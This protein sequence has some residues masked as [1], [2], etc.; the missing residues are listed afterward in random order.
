MTRKLPTYLDIEEFKRLISKTNKNKIRYKIGFLLGFGAGLR[1]S[2]IVG[3]ENKIKPLT[4]D[5]IDLKNKR[6]RIEGAKGGVDRIVPIPKGFK[7]YMIKELPL[8][9]HY[10]N[11]NSARRSFQRAFLRTA[12]KAGLLEKK[13][14]LHFHSLR[15]GF[16]SRL[17]RQGVPIHHIRELMGHS[18][19]STTNIYLQANPEQ[20]LEDYERLF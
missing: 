8:T 6:I 18:N 12:K 20:A 5:N 14:N 2:E 16:G 1:L 4:K 10:S 17:A 13:P 15:H 7:E 9:K 3:L 19:I 11:I